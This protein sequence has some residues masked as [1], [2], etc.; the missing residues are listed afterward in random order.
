LCQISN[1][2]QIQDNATISMA[3][4]NSCTRIFSRDMIDYKL[5]ARNTPSGIQI[6]ESESWKL[7][8]NCR[9]QSLFP[10]RDGSSA[11]TNMHFPCTKPKDKLPSTHKPTVWPH[12]AAYKYTPFSHALHFPLNLFTQSGFFPSFFVSKSFVYI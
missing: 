2:W 1:E 10:E 9:R 6:R 5:R 12:K 3:T 8:R 7:E 11:E 4:A